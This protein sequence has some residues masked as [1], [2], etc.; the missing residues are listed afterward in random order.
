MPLF[1]DESDRA[2]SVN[3]LCIACP[4]LAVAIGYVGRVVCELP[5]LPKLVMVFT[6]FVI[7]DCGTNSGGAAMP[8][9]MLVQP[10]FAAITPDELRGAAGLLATVAVEPLFVHGDETPPRE[11]EA[12]GVEPAVELV[13]EFTACSVLDRKPLAAEFDQFCAC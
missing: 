5:E 11:D 12:L 6:V 8:V 7:G 4:S 2:G 1:D 13:K 10:P 3:T 9:P